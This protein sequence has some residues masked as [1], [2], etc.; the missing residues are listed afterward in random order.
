MQKCNVND[1]VECVGDLN[2]NFVYGIN[3]KGNYNFSSEFL[4]WLIE[5]QTSTTT[6]KCYGLGA[7]SPFRGASELI[8]FFP[9]S[10]L[11]LAKCA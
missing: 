8:P 10:F 6:E 2:T 9:C 5:Y 4:N 7:T 1:N 11:S 3:V